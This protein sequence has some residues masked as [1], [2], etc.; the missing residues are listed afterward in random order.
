[1]ILIA[2]H[3]SE[4]HCLYDFRKLPEIMVMV[5]NDVLP[6]PPIGVVSQVRTSLSQCSINPTSLCPSPTS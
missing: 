1:M 6:I 3:L 2:L 4:E 5:R